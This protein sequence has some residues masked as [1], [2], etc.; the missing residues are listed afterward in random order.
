M[1]RNQITDHIVQFSQ[2]GQLMPVRELVVV[3][4][5]DQQANRVPERFVGHGCARFSRGS[6]LW[7]LHS[8]ITRSRAQLDARPGAGERWILPLDI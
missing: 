6:Q 1:E 5:W 7:R 4:G 8:R 2:E 3:G